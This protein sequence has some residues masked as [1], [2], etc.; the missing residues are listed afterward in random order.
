MSGKTKRPRCESCGTSA[1][2]HARPRPGQI[3]GAHGALRWL[4]GDCEYAE[5]HDDAIRIE[6]AKRPKTPQMETLW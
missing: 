1:N 3:E 6:R 4:C 5:L 2:V